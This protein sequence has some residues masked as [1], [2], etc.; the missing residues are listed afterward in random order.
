[1]KLPIAEVASAAEPWLDLPANMR[2]L[3]FTTRPPQSFSYAHRCILDF[4]KLATRGLTALP[5]LLSVIVDPKSQV[6]QRHV[7]ACIFKGLCPINTADHLD[8]IGLN[9]AHLYRKQSNT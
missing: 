7:S 1:M 2:S 5:A 9:L 3:S 6:Q 4:E 8:R